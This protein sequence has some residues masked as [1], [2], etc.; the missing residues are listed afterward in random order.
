MRYRFARVL[1]IGL[2]FF[3]G[4]GAHND[5]QAKGQD[6]IPIHL[7]MDKYFILYTQPSPPFMDGNNRLLFP[8]RAIQDLMGGT[9]SYNPLTKTAA[10][11]LLDHE[12]N[13]AIHSNLATV[14]DSSII[15]DT[16]PVLIKGSMF[17]PLRLFLDHTDAKYTWDQKMQLLQITDERIVIGQPFVDFMGNDVTSG[18]IDGAFQLTSFIMKP[19]SMS[20]TALNISGEDVA[21]GIADIHPLVSFKDGGFSTDAYSK[22]SYPDLP[23]VK[24]N[25]S[26]TVKRPLDAKNTAYIISVGRRVP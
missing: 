5:A 23:A 17:L 18:H 13:V 3:A 6:E 12:F 4:F 14:D 26:I 10:I 9:V 20:V 24:K 22:P 15:M 1:L 19:H 25:H 8:L 7:K 21:K 11:S 2:I 16:Q